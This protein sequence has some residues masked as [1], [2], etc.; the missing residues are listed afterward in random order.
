M[1]DQFN[2][3]NPYLPTAEQ[4]SYPA[5]QDSLARNTLELARWQT[6]FSILLI[7]LFLL[8]MGFFAVSLLN[9]GGAGGPSGVIGGVA[10]VGAISL[11]VYGLP[12]VVLWRAAAGARKY[13][14]SMKPEHLVQFTSSQLVFWRTVGVISVL[15]MGFYGV[16]LIV[17]FGF[18]AA[19]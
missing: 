15:V 14:R 2:D 8:M 18:G 12:A 9:A 3:V 13:S 6:F 7:L 4:E 17:A 10:C 1:S 19:F 11:L 16:A 5:D